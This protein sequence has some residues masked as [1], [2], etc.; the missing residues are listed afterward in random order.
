MDKLNIDFSHCVDHRTREVLG[1]ALTRAVIYD[2]LAN[3]N[4]SSKVRTA[5][6]LELDKLK[7]I[8]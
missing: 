1:E 3:E 4:I 2:L 5:T 7:R 8:K 6:K